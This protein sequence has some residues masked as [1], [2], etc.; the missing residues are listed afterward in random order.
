[1]LRMERVQY[2]GIRTA[3]G[4]MC[5]TPNNSL[6]DLSGIAPLAERFVY[7]NFRYL[8]AVFYRLDHPL[9]RRLETRG[10]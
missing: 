4:L 5:L 2:R 9:K 6:G 8:V 7:L 10:S 3:V 1:M